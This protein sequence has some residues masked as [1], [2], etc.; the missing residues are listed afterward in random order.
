[1]NSE[2]ALADYNKNLSDLTSDYKNQIIN[3]QREDEEK[4]DNRK[5]NEQQTQA[6]RDWQAEQDRINREW[7]AQQ[8]QAQRDWQSQENALDRKQYSGRSGYSYGGGYSGYGS[9]GSGYSSYSRRSNSV[10]TDDEITQ[11]A[12]DNDFKKLSTDAYNAVDTG[13]IGDLMERASLYDELTS[14]MY[15]AYY[16]QDDTVDERLNNTR[17]TALKHLYNKSY[18]RSTNGAYKIGNTVYK[19]N[20]P[21]RQDYIDKVKQNKYKTQADYYNKYSKNETTKR[22]ANQNAKAESLHNKKMSSAKKASTKTNTSTKKSTTTSK[23]K[24][25]IKKSI[26]NSKNNAKSS[27]TK[28]NQNTKKATA[29]AS[30]NVKKSTSNASKNFKNNVKKAVKKIFKKK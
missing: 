10:D 18:A 29:N 20:A 3:W 9:G 6:E 23:T 7:E 15:S 13:G 21:L 12:I 1:M 30:K 26:S 22:K 16:G 27:T 4:E 25:T 24:N 8:S 17:E 5:Y 28:A 19:H 2:K 14:P 11:Q